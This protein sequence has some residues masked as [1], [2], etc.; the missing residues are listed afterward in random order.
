MQT[1]TGRAVGCPGCRSRHV[2]IAHWE[3]ACPRNG[4]GMPCRAGA[5]P[6]SC[7]ACTRASV[8]VAMNRW[9]ARRSCGEIFTFISLSES[10]KMEK[11]WGLRPRW[12]TRSFF[13][14]SAAGRAEQSL[15]C[16]SHKTAAA[17]P[18]GTC[19]RIDR[20]VLLHPMAGLLWRS[21]WSMEHINHAVHPALGA[22]PWA[23]SRI[24]KHTYSSGT[25]PGLSWLHPE[26]QMSLGTTPRHFMPNTDVPRSGPAQ[27]PAASLL[28]Y[29]EHSRLP[30]T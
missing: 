16:S 3:G 1:H 22:A 29:L 8:P 20:H 19:T 17:G 15:A 18:H 23:G 25:S 10:L 11:S 21:R 12:G 14:L 30:D 5:A 24:V 9:V 7:R 26:L 4:L 27:P 6:G 28:L 2:E 13:R